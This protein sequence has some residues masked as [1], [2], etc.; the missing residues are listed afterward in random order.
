MTVQELER[1]LFHWHAVVR[2]ATPGSWAQS[3][4]R[5]IARKASAKPWWRPSPKE[6]RVMKKMV[7]DL[8]AHGAGQDV[9]L[10]EE[11]D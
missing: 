5:S 9:V 6:W 4:A 7:A 2:A 10:I 3:F 1:A 11:V 8:F